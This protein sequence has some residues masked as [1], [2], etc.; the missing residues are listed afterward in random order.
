MGR[1]VNFYMSETDEVEFIEYVRKTGKIEILPSRMSSPSERLDAL[2]KPDPSIAFCR[3]FLYNSEIQGKLAIEFIEQRKEYYVEPSKSPVIEFCLSTRSRNI[4]REGR[5]WAELLI[6][7]PEMGTFVLKS[8]EFK[9]WYERIAGWLR[10]KYKRVG[11]FY[12]GPGAL[13]FR[14]E[15]GILEGLE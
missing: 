4:L 9:R 6:F 15:G 10:R 2:P 13:K 1:Q 14:E 3:V 12:A 8:P 11:S 5:I 7:D